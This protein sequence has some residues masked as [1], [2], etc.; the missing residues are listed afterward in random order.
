MDAPHSDHH[1]GRPQ[2]ISLERFQ[3]KRRKRLSSTERKAAPL[4]TLVVLQPSY[5]PWLGFFDQV[6]RCDHFVFYDDVQFDKHGWRN[7]NRVKSNRGPVWLTAPVRAGGRMGQ[8]INEVEIADAT[9]WARKHLQT[10]DQLYARS[11]HRDAYLPELAEALQRK[12]ERLADLDIELSRMMCRWFG[13]DRP[14][15]RSSEL[16]V[17]GDRN[18]RLLALCKYFGVDTYLSGDSARVYLD[19]D[20]FAAHGVRV[21]WQDFRH[22]QYP[23]MHGEFIP[24]LSALDLMLNLGEQSRLVLEG[25]ARQAAAQ[26]LEG[27]R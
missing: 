21:E 7:R 5:L 24:Y 12:W 8:L 20:L 15:Y 6:R 16:D 13:L 22:P 23:Q 1:G 18:T 27:D 17:H 2:G 10:I 26:A 4:T 14:M 25:G 9:P 11:P 19:I 3:P